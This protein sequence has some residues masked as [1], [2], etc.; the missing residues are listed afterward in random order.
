MSYLAEKRGIWGPFM[1]VSPSS[2]LHNWQQEIE[3][4]CPDLKVLPYWGSVKDRK[5]LRKFW[6]PPEKLYQRNSPFHVLITSYGLILEDEK[7]FNKIHWQYLIL[8]EAHAIKSSKSQRW[9]TL[10]N[11]RCRNRMLLTVS[12]N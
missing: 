1:I 4:F 5:I 11:F 2:T 10:L 12:N 6:S 3:K 9:Q 8:D 7:A